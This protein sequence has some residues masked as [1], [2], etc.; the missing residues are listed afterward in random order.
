MQSTPTINEQVSGFLDFVAQEFNTK[1]ELQEEFKSTQGWINARIGLKSDDGLLEQA[2]IIQDGVIRVAD[3]I[4]NAANLTIIFTKGTD[5]VEQLQAS[6]DEAYMMILNGR[7]R[8]EGNTSYMGFWDYLVNLL[9]AEDQQKAVDAQIEEHHQANLHLAEKVSTHGRM[10]RKQRK[11]IRLKGRRVDPGVKHLD[12][13]Y[14][15]KY[16][17]D[18]FPRLAQFRETRLKSRPEVCAEYGKLLTDFFVKHGYEKKAN[19]QPWEPNMRCA[20]SFKYIMEHRK[21]II[22]ENDLIAGSYTSN[23]VYGMVAQPNI[24]GAPYFWGELRSCQN[25]ELEPYIITEETIQTLHKHVYPYWKDRNMLQWWREE[26]ESPLGLKIHDRYFSL[27]L[28]KTIDNGVHSPGYEKVLKDGLKA[29]KAQIDEELQRSTNADEEKKSTL[30]AMNIGLDGVVAY[31]RN[32]AK[33][34]SEQAKVETNPVRKAELKHIYSTLRHIQEHPAHTL[35]EAVQALII[36][37]YAVGLET[38][39]DGPSLGRLDQILQPYFEKDMAKLISSNDREMYIKH[40]LELIGCLF[41]RINSH[42]PLTPSLGT[43]LNSGSPFNTTIVV[44]GVT[45]QGEDAVNDMSYII[46]KVTE[47][48]TMNDPNMHARYNWMKNSR[49][50]LERV[51]EVN[52]ITGAT[53]AIHGDE[54]MIAALTHNNIA[55]ADARD[56]TPTGCVEPSIPGKQLACTSSG[57][58]SLAAPLE[59]ALNNGIH[60]LMQWDLGPKTGRIEDDVFKT[61]EDF[62]LA[63]K[64]QCEF[65]F[66]Q[67]VISDNQL[68]KL[69]TAHYPQTLMSILY[70][71]CVEKGRNVNRG[72]TKYNSTGITFVGLSDVVDSLMVIKKL[73]FDEKRIT[74]TELKKALDNNYGGFEKIHAMVKNTVPRFGSRNQDAVTMANRVTK[75]TNDF[76]RSRTDGR[77]GH[78]TT[79]WWTMNNHTVYGRVTGALPSGRLKGTPFTPGLTPSPDASHNLLDNLLD[80]AELDP[81][82]L[83]NNIAFNVRIVPSP[84]DSHEE[85]VKRMADYMETYF[86]KGGMQVQFN[87]IDTDTLKDAM[88]HPEYYHDL[89]VRISGYCGYFTKLQR[90]LQL[91]IIRRSEYGL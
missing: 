57:L 80:V 51:C 22:R 21:P 8:T 37:H 18:D 76:F 36:M 88:A 64:K 7:V 78:Y 25:R 49:T 85:T 81:R 71:G 50:F 40:A 3:R 45:R 12:D 73:V 75:M 87:V 17:L 62:Y 74:L 19:G 24:L 77:G 16:S 14:L 28:Y 33:L 38:I 1:P 70:D 89:M 90:D 56:W 84:K 42:W 52:Y 61:F 69:C 10:D 5:V 32:L 26:F 11:D 15:S 31:I 2:I 72:G 34:A 43:W 63:F 82:T 9:L 86:K 44:G 60:P 41:L 35:D 68:E 27:E 48:L 46:L 13:P 83:D 59:M 79:G 6:P 67:L 58:V 39:D 54:T 20:K 65:L 55:V 91:E 53:P 66:E 30:A 29:L 4:P 23:P 47:M